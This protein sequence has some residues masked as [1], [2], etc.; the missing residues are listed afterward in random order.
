MGN[1]S[2]ETIELLKES[3]REWTTDVQQVEGCYELF[4]ENCREG[5]LPRENLQKV[6][7]YPVELTFESIEDKAKRE[8]LQ[9][10]PTS[11]TLKPGQVDELESTAA[12]LLKQN[13]QFQKFLAAFSP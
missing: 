12:E 8:R 2:Y 3:M 10:L 1:Y 4:Q 7:Y 13:P 6:T 9:S 11:F 5:E